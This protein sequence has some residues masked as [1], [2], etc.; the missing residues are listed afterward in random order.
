MKR[1]DGYILRFINHEGGATQQEPAEVY[2]ASEVDAEHIKLSEEKYQE[3]IIAMR[4]AALIAVGAISIGRISE[5]L[6]LGQFVS[7]DEINIRQA[8]DKLLSGENDI[9]ADRAKD[10]EEIADF[11]EGVEGLK[12]AIGDLRDER[13]KYEE[14]LKKILAKDNAQWW[15]DLEACIEIA[16]EALEGK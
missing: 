14:A 13:D 9:G 15:D 11:K 5:K 10:K 3:G 4:D 2:L 8:A 12:M 1:Y 6:G 7:E 16:R